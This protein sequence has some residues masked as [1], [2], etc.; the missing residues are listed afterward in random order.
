MRAPFLLAGLGSGLGQQLLD[1]VVV[2]I[3]A[4][5]AVPAAAGAPAVPA[6]A[7]PEAAAG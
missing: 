2:D 7:V 6:G 1:D 5:D 3:E 4:L